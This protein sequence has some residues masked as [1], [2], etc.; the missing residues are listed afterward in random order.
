VRDQLAAAGWTVQIADARKAKAVGSLAAK[1]DKLD[2]RVL[3]ELAR[4]DL[5]PQVHVPTFAD[6]ELKE[7]LGR[8]MHLVRLR[9]AA[10][11]RAHGVLSQFG[12]TLAFKRLREPDRDELL[13]QRGLPEVW[14]RSIAEAVAVVAMLDQRLIPLEQE[15]RPVARPTRASGCWSRSPASGTSSVSRSPQR[16][17]T[18]PGSPQH[19]S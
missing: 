16:S 12:V 15:L 10:M 5:V 7:R 3:A 11:N 13:R 4:R 9:T 18:S 17:A 19:G 2:A 14:R 1:T 8:R 6:R